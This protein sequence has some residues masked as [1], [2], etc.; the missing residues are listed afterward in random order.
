MLKDEALDYVSD[1]QSPACVF[2]RSTQACVAVND[3]ALRLLGVEREDATEL[4]MNDVCPAHDEARS[5]LMRYAGVMHRTGAA[6]RA[7]TYD[8]MTQELTDPGGA[9]VLALLIDRPVSSRVHALLRERDELVSA[10]SAHSPDI[11]AR[12]DSE[13]RHVYIN[14]AVVDGARSGTHNSPGGLQAQAGV[15][16]ELCVRW[17]A[18]ARRVFASGD[19]YRFQMSV[20][21]GNAQKH[22]QSEMLPEA[23]ADGAVRSVLAIARDVTARKTAELEL[24]RARTEGLRDRHALEVLAEA[25]PHPVRIYDRN[26]S[27][28]H[29]NAACEGVPALSAAELR[30]VLDSGVS[31]TSRVEAARGKDRTTYDAH[32]LPV[33]GDAGTVEAV[34]WV[35]FEAAQAERAANEDAYAAARQR[36]AFVR[37]VHHRVKNNLQGVVGLL[38]QLANRDVALQV[39][40]GK[41]IVQL[42]AIAVIHGLQGQ[43]LRE[44]V[45]IT[46]MIEEIATSVARATGVPIEYEAPIGDA[47][48]VV[49]VKENEAVTIALVLNELMMNAAKHRREGGKVSVSSLIHSKRALIEV[50]NQGAIEGAFDYARDIG[51]GT[52]LELVKALLPDHGV[53]LTYAQHGGCV[54]ATLEIAAPVLATASEPP[55]SRDD[56]DRRKRPHSDRRR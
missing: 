22:Y 39:A 3:A 19:P 14:P 15:P 30:R 27:T 43:E 18:E 20:A 49:C 25:L 42:Q 45:P 17:A 52:G 23:D 38:R 51:I 16:L 37:E 12:I 1:T 40:L 4:R 55:E 13:L 54:K 10:L 53:R 5:S 26:L 31:A 36:N 56:W 11:V 28:V 46:G 21:A 29:A 34:L 48:D 33:L 44:D 2:D 7:I 6:D 50:A 24:A 41:A 9:C 47:D 32:A 35:A 8:V